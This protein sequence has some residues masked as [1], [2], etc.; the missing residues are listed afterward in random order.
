M[1]EEQQRIFEYLNN[2]AIGYE[3]RKTSSEIRINCN[4]ESGGVTNEHVRD[5]IRGMILNHRCCIGSMMWIDGYWIIQ[6][7]Q[8]LEMSI[9]SLMQR[10]N[11]VIRR[12][13]AL[14]ANF[15]NEN[16]E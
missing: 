9:E 10:A 16:N 2:N 5:L 3:E 14:R 1:N 12:A 11:G 8:E 13:E 6:N 15:L 4:L 7:N